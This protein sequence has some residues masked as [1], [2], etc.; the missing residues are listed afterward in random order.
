M[1]YFNNFIGHTSSCLNQD[2]FDIRKFVQSYAVRSKRSFIK[3][4]DHTEID[5]MI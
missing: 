2:N 3:E 1:Y 4:F 5:G